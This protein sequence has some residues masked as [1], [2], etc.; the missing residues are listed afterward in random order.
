MQYTLFLFIFISCSGPIKPQSSSSTLTVDH[1][2]WDALL[3]KYVSDQGDVDYNA[4]T[5]DTK[6]LDAYLEKLVENP[7]ADTASKNEKLAYY[8]NLYNAG[9]VQLILENY[10][11]ESIKDISRPWDKNRFTIG[12]DDY[13]LG[14]IEHKILRKMNEPR[15]HFA[16]NCA[17]YSC[18]RLLNEAFSASKMEV[19]LEESTVVFVNDPKRNKIAADGIRISEIFKWFKKDFTSEGTLVAY[20][21]Q[22]SDIKLK[23]GEKINYLDYDWHLNEAK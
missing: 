7:I 3:K 19:Q 13:S 17:S 22:Y 1:A 5:G 21:N 4:F 18:P 11:L 23:A 6:K 9:T 8:I 14:D 15:I 12:G 20:L 16:I 10:P 2:E